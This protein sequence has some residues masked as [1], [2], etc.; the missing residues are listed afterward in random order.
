MFVSIITRASFLS[1]KASFDKNYQS[2]LKKVKFVNPVVK[3]QETHLFF[4]SVIKSFN[5]IFF[6]LLKCFII[7]VWVREVNVSFIFLC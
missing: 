2:L 3:F 4:F 5:L 6:N 7:I 1:F